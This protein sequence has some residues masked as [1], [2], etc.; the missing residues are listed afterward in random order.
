MSINEKNPPDSGGF[1]SFI[2]TENDDCVKI[3]TD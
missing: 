1:F 3:K 2:V